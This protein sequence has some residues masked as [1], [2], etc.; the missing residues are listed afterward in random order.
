MLI[1]GIWKNV[2]ST[3]VVPSPVV[4]GYLNLESVEKEN[5]LEIRIV[6]CLGR[7]LDNLTVWDKP[8]GYYLWIGNIASGVYTVQLVFKDRIENHKVIKE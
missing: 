3:S 8:Y 1:K 5:L 6:D 2:T 7:R 4:Y